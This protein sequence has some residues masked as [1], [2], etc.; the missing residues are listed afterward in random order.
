M[1][2]PVVA[3]EHTRG[4]KAHDLG[5]LLIGSGAVLL[6][7]TALVFVLW[8]ALSSVSATG[9]DA[10]GVRCYAKAA[11]MTCLKTANPSPIGD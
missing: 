5:W 3:H 2:V 4:A 6:A 1:T 11:A 9:F 10:D 7:L 8:L